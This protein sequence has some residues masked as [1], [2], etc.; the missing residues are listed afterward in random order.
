MESVL[1]LGLGVIIAA[2]ILSILMAILNVNE[3]AF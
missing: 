2:I 1:I 3:L